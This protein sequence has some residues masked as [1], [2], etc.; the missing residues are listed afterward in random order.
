MWINTGDIILLGLRE[1]QDEKADVIHKYTPEQARV[2][3][4][5]GQLPESLE[6]HDER[7]EGD[8]IFRKLHWAS[9]VCAHLIRYY[10]SEDTELVAQ[11]RNY[12][13]ESS[14]SEE[15]ESDTEDEDEEDSDE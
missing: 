9:E 13:I 6:F 5:K 11:D 4:A 8:I 12:D 2:L 1:Y 15:Y 3:K 7:D 14:S 10:L